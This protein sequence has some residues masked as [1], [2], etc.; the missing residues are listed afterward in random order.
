MYAHNQNI[1]YIL[2]TRTALLY[3]STSIVVDLQKSETSS[4]V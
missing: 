1:D 2:F 4:M 3:L